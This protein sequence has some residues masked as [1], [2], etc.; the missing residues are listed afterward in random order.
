MPGRA[1][2]NWRTRSDATLHQSAAM[3]LDAEARSGA[4]STLAGA[5]LVRAGRV[6]R[7]A[8][9]TWQ[10]GACCSPS[11]LPAAEEHCLDE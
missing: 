10:Y 3:A 6:H 8:P 2:N 9:A 5:A 4:F 7:F 11:V 1:S